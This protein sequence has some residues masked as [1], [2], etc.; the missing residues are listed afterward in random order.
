[1]PILTV[2]EIEYAITRGVLRDKSV[3]SSTALQAGRPP[4]AGCPGILL[5][6]LSGTF[7]AW[8]PFPA[9]IKTNKLLGP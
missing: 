4:I 5:D 7:Y 2:T 9:H 6:I 1:M 3:N 8:R